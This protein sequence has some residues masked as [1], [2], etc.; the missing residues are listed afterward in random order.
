MKQTII[1]SLTLL[2]SLLSITAN[3][4][5]YLPDSIS[6]NAVLSFIACEPGDE[7]YEAFGHAAIRVKD[8]EQ[9]IDLCYH[10]GLFDFSNDDFIYRF[11]KGETDYMMGA[12]DYDYFIQ[13]YIRRGSTVHEAILRLNQQQKQ[14]IYSQLRTN[15]R[16]ENITYRYNYVYDNCS[17]RPIDLILKSSD[18]IKTPD[19]ITT[20]TFRDIISDYVSEGSWL[21]SGIDLV[22]SSLA[23]RQITNVDELA[24]P[25]YALNYLKE[26]TI[27]GQPL[28]EEPHTLTVG[29]DRS[30]IS[31]SP[32]KFPLFFICIILAIALS[33]F[34]FKFKTPPSISITVLLIISFLFG[35]LIAFLMFISVHPLVNFNY[36]F[37]WL[38][39]L[40]II[41]IYNIFRP[42]SR[43]A[44]ITSLIAMILAGTTGIIFMF[45]IQSP[46]LP[47]IGLWILFT[48]SYT[49]IY[50]H[51][52]RKPI[53]E[54]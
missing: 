11:V 38:N 48:T 37:L 8:T 9:K 12:F 54:K 18:Q 41:L 16:P 43:F 51:T 7:V 31:D 10:W 2:F 17:T 40:Y 26:C 49:L 1:S 15:A 32:L 22:V 45:G 5:S 52:R 20:G 42:S 27:N 50:L 28:I 25:I 4:Q 13:E 33:A 46:C 44:S 23:D 53:N 21:S 6:E 24:F 14:Y 35:S 3:S 30:D 47:I 39:P 29:K 34:Y 36:N 19:T